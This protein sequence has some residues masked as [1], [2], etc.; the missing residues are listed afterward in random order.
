MGGTFPSAPCLL[1]M[2]WAAPIQRQCDA[3]FWPESDLAMAMVARPFCHRFPTFRT[4][5]PLR[6]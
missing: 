4:G 1:L 3:A 6:R 2:Q 5:R